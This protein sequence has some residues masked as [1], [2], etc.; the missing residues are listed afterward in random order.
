MNQNQMQIFYV[1]I[2]FIEVI[3]SLM[4]NVDFYE[5]IG[6]GIVYSQLEH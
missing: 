3:R 6:N 4:G 5:I 2:H 1:D